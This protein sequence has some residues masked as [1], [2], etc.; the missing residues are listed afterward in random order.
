MMQN[1]LRLGAG[2]MVWISQLVR[3]LLHVLSEQTELFIFFSE[4]KE[5]LWFSWAL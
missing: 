4:K 5:K 2:I 3:L 1:E